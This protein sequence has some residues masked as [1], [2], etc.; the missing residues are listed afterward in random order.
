[1]VFEHGKFHHAAGALT[2][3]VLRPYAFGLP[4]YVATE[5]VA[6]GLIALRDTRTPLVTNSLQLMG[7]AALMALICDTGP[8]YAA[9][10]RADTDHASCAE[11]IAM[12]FRRRDGSTFVWRY[13]RWS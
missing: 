4:A 12:M 13:R 6:R 3:D 10:D 5:V 11:V 8:L 1:M 9:M 7:R 2:Y